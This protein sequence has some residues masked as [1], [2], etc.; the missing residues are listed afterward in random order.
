MHTQT[1]VA[2]RLQDE[3]AAGKDR[4]TADAVRSWIEEEDPA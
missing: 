1:Q 4:I 2:A 3:G